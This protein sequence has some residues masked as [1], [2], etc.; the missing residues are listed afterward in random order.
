MRIYEGHQKCLRVAITSYSKRRS[1]QWRILANQDTKRRILVVDDQPDITLTTEVELEEE[2]LFDVDT[3]TD[4]ELALSSF[5]PGIYHLVILDI[6]MPKMDGFEL[7]E[8]L[9]KVDPGI[10]VCFLTASEMYHEEMREI[11][12]CALNK[13]LFLQNQYRLMI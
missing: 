3:F 8:R 4:P 12:H 6:V 7:Y 9:K 13:D 5:K 10:N 2:G 1:H 11:E